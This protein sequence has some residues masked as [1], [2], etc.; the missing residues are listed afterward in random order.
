MAD[1]IAEVMNILNPMA[2]EKNT[3]NAAT[4]GLGFH[5]FDGKVTTEEVLQQ[6]GGNFN[7]EEQKI[8]RLPQSVI[9]SI[10]NGE[11]VTIDPKYII[12]SH[13]AT[14]CV[15]HDSTIGIVGKDYGV[16]QNNDAFQLLDLMCNASVTDNPLNIVSAGRVRDFEPYIQAEMPNSATSLYGDN[17]DT[18]F[19]CF[20]RTS[21]DGT[22]GLQVRFSPVRV[23]CQNTFMMNVCS[24]GLTYKHTKNI[25]KRVDL[26][27]EVNINRV[28][29][30]LNSLNIM[31]ND[32]IEQMNSFAVAKVSQEQ[33]NDYVMNLFIDDEKMRAE[34]KK[35]N[36]NLDLVED[37]ST[38]TKNIIDSFRNTLESGI[39]Q[40]TNRGTKLWL[41][42]GTTNYF[43]N[44]ANYGSKKDNDITIATKR[45]TAM[46]EGKA[47]KKIDKA[48]EL[49]TA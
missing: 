29:E 31:K 24:K 35:H 8:V 48:F 32:Y 16:V 2:E 44:V 26:T 28:K 42:N 17:S 3:M 41:F 9:E 39:G 1:I 40:D 11:S 43:S 46:E 12:D 6:I 19:Y 5:Q 25:G 13:K 33:I 4:L 7:V 23:I 47:S 37:L 10:I 22:C 45:F 36:Y 21:H 34:A 49:L 38:R 14:V 18:K 30:V 15:E 27:K 20:V